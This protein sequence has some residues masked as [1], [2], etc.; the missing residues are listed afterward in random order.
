MI[1]LR[2]L[3]ISSI[4]TESFTIHLFYSVLLTQQDDKTMEISVCTEL[5]VEK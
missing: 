4:V 5:A 3:E 2:R 1:G